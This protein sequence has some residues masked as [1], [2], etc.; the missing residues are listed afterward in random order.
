MACSPL[1]PPEPCPRKDV[2]REKWPQLF[3]LSFLSPF[4][5]QEAARPTNILISM[6]QELY[7]P[8]SYSQGPAEAWEAMTQAQGTV[9]ECQGLA[10]FSGTSETILNVERQNEHTCKEG[11]TPISCHISK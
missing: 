7:D 5:K 4:Q 8:S 9:A 3:L 11:D 2:I 1:W 10:L 6:N